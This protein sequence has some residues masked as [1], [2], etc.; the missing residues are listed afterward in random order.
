MGHGKI[1]IA[2]EKVEKIKLKKRPK[3]RRQMSRV[4]LC[5]LW[6]HKS[7]LILKRPTQIAM[8]P[9]RSKMLY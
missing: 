5:E 6:F 3:R 8:T 9:A 1:E 4:W 2:P 7:F